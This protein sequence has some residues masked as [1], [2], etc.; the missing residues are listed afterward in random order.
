METTTL[1][2]KSSEEHRRT[3]ADIRDG[4][5]E[6]DIRDVRL[7]ADIRDGRLEGDTIDGPLGTDLRGVKSPSMT[8]IE[9]LWKREGLVVL[10]SCRHG[11]RKA[12][13]ELSPVSLFSFCAGLLD[14][15]DF[16][17][18]STEDEDEATDRA[19]VGG[20]LIL[21]PRAVA[22]ATRCLHD[23]ILKGGLERLASGRF[24]RT[25]TLGG[26][27]SLSLGT[28]SAASDLATRAL[29]GG[30]AA[31]F[32]RPEL[33]VVW[34]D[35]HADINTPSTSASGNLHGCPLS[36]LLGLDAPG[37]DALRHFG[38]VKDRLAATGA[39]R[40]SYLLPGHLLYIGLRDVE[41]PEQALLA[42]H[43]IEAYSMRRVRADQRGMDALVKEALGKVDPAGERP[44]HVSFDI[45][46]IDP[47][48]APG[49]GTAVGGGL[50][51]EEG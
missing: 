28:I 33:V 6:G 5:L 24:P 11:Q 25:L 20:A 35:A 17:L 37:W 10:A 48:F 4:Q 38:W 42:E 14:K 51:V 49:T 46:A 22:A 7:E 31:P 8:G 45:D 32:Q 19:L 44:I 16:S 50:T 43:R 27:H 3:E 2:T 23:E 15:I 36:A 21:R 13:V 41:P 30:L 9:R 18:P 1:D 26:D 34:V 29:E 39:G 40:T 47:M 12:G